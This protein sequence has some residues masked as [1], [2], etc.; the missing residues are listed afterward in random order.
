MKALVAVLMIGIVM[1]VPILG[2]G[3][4][5]GEGVPFYIKVKPP[6]VTH[7]YAGQAYIFSVTVLSDEAGRAVN[8]SASVTDCDVTVSPRAIKPGQVSRI[9]VVPGDTSVGKTLI[10]TI[11]G[12]R[13]GLIEIETATIEMGDTGD[14][15]EGI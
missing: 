12:E 3:D 5:A 10:I 6:L 11:E 9:T 13:D 8:I 15:G 4:E 2:C 14:S 7:A 1:V